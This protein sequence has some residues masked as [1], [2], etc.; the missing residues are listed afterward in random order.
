MRKTIFQCVGNTMLFTLFGL[1]FLF[2]AS[3][4]TKSEMGF[5][6][7]LTIFPFLLLAFFIA[8]PIMYHILAKKYQWG[9]KNNSELS[10][11]DERE[12]I[13]VAESTKT[14][15]TVLIGGVLFIIAVIGGINVFSLF[16]GM[17]IS[18]YPISI[19]LLT[20]LLNI[21]MISYCVKWCLEYKK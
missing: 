18:I 8:Y 16:T 17:T 20:L 21:A 2:P 4:V 3:D 6:A 19:T 11:S 9:K 15:Y 5:S 10:Y 1:A 13:I 12:K 7:S 14:A